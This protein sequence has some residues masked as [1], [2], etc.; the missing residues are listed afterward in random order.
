M[1]G[2]TRVNNCVKVSE[3]VENIMDALI[4]KIIINEA[5]SNNRK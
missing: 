2:D 5:V 3:D 1:K 4:N